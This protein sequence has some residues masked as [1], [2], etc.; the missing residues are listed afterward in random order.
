M[1]TKKVLDF[2]ADY[3]APDLVIHKNNRITDINE[4]NQKIVIEAKHL[5]KTFGERTIVKDYEFAN[6]RI[7]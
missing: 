5:S 7:A 4:R 1:E 2:S 6:R 3:T